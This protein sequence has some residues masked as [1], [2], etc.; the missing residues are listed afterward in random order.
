MS[1]LPARC[2][3]APNDHR[4]S[5]R[6]GPFVTP[7]QV[8]EELQASRC[9][10]CDTRSQIVSFRCRSADCSSSKRFGLFESGVNSAQRNVSREADGLTFVLFLRLEISTALMFSGLAA[11][12]WFTSRQFPSRRVRLRRICGFSKQKNAGDSGKSPAS[13]LFRKAEIEANASS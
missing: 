6:H 10:L 12:S 5:R 2:S 7:L 4:N 11:F 9:T 13:K 8:P 3:V 1:D